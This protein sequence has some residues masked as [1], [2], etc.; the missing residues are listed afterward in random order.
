MQGFKHTH[1][2]HLHLQTQIRFFKMKKIFLVLAS[3]IAL[4]ACNEDDNKIE[5]SSTAV[6]TNSSV[7]TDKTSNSHSQ[8][9][10]PS[11]YTTIEWIDGIEKDFGKINQGEKLNIVFRFKNTGTKPLIVKSVTPG[12]GCTLADKPE[13]PIAPGETGEIKAGFDSQGRTGSQTKNINVVT[14]TSP[15]TTS[16]IFHVDIKTKS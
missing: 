8:T 12:C 2:F 16:L 3:G 9:N 1:L 10:D 14:N 11:N 7:A 15:E 5:S 13:K 4:M 6:S